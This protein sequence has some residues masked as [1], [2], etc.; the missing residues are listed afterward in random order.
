M[1]KLRTYTKQDLQHSNLFLDATTQRLLDIY[2]K[3]QH[4]NSEVKTSWC[5]TNIQIFYILAQKF[6]KC[7]WSVTLKYPSNHS[8]ESVAGLTIMKTNSDLGSGASRVSGQDGQTFLIKSGTKRRKNFFICPL[9][10]SVCPACPPQY[11]GTDIKCG[12]GQ[13]NHC[14]NC[15]MTWGPR[16]WGGKLSE[17][18]CTND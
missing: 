7:D 13:I 16:H 3:H 18:F 1:A 9:W 2:L 5:Y 17:F 11:T 8:L 6:D 14:A 10:F 4:S 15:S 12:Q